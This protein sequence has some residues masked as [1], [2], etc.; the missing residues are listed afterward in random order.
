M[1]N[2]SGGSFT[3]TRMREK[4]LKALTG[5]CNTD[6]DKAT[7]NGFNVSRTVDRK[8]YR[9]AQPYNFQGPYMGEPRT[10]IT[11]E[12]EFD[13]NVTPGFK[14]MVL[15][16]IEIETGLDQ[17]AKRERF[18]KAEAELKAAQA[19]YNQAKADIQ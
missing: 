18:N 3:D 6:W 17:A 13:D 14:S 5:L 10:M 15:D 8:G 4:V 16:T 7:I 11:I 1:V 12:V 9:T 19:K 2:F